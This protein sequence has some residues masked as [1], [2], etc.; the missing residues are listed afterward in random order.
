MEEDVPDIDDITGKKSLNATFEIVPNLAQWVSI[1]DYNVI[2]E[3][4]FVFHST[5]PKVGILSYNESNYAWK[6]NTMQ[7]PV[8]SVDDWIDIAVFTYYMLQSTYS[9]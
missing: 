1:T 3:R 5:L 7:L 4:F 8:T 2:P 6:T 9:N